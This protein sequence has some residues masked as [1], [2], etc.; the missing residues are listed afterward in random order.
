MV[1]EEKEVLQRF[2]Q[3]SKQYLTATPSAQDEPAGASRQRPRC[4]GRSMPSQSSTARRKSRAAGT[5]TFAARHRV[6]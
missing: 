5:W 4:H 6:S 2:L 3:T 1:D